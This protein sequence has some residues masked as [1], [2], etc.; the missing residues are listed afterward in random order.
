MLICVPV[1]NEELVLTDF[2]QSL[3]LAILYYLEH[4]KHAAITVKFC[5]NGTDRSQEV[6]EQTIG[7]LDLPYTVI[8]MDSSPKGKIHAQRTMLK[9]YDQFD[10][11]LFADADTVV[12][13]GSIDALYRELTTTENLLVY[14]KMIPACTS[15]GLLPWL[16]RV[17]Y[18]WQD[19]ILSPRNYFHGRFFMVQSSICSAFYDN[20]SG[21]GDLV[22]GFRVDDIYLSRNLVHI[23]GTGRMKEVTDAR[24]WFGMITSFSDYYRA[25]KRLYREILRLDAL[26]PEHAYV[27]PRY[28][29]RKIEKEK[30]RRLP[31]AVQGHYLAYRVFDRTMQKVV[32]LSI[33]AE[34]KG[35]K[36]AS[37]MWKPTIST[38]NK[39]INS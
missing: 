24:V 11:V 32:S 28:F 27:Q 7:E 33:L 17:H 1:Y 2:I 9:D 13:K 15:N 31:L 3:H 14:G 30:L 38:K 4:Y 21:L 6:L 18:Q 22:D 26:Y 37:D 10:Y 29:K 35:W 23:Y 5:F 8:T 12:D 25:V 36:R 19:H 39:F 34:Q 16:Q 20:R